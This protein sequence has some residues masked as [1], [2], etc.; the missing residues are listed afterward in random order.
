MQQLQDNLQVI[1]EKA[2]GYLATTKNQQE[3]Q[4]VKRELQHCRDAT[5]QRI[6]KEREVFDLMRLQ[7][8]FV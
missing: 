7:R 5:V 8:E 3:V 2:A 4:R 1:E 6:Q